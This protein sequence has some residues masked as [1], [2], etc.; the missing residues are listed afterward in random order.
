MA[1]IPTKWHEVSIQYI[2]KSTWWILCMDIHTRINIPWNLCIMDILGP[3]KSVKVS[4]SFY[5]IKCNLGLQ[6]SVWIIQVSLFFS[7]HINRFQC[8]HIQTYTHIMQVCMGCM[9]VLYMCM[10]ARYVATYYYNNVVGIP[11]QNLSISFPLQLLEDL[12]VP[13]HI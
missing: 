7:V 12:S 5:M 3:K 11:L 8:I 6:S 13:M 2:S 4:R 10:Y 1:L 9:H